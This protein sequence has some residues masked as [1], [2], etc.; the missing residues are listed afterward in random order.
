MR[1]LLGAVATVGLLTGCGG[2]Y[3]AAEVNGAAARLEYARVVGAESLAPYEY[4]YAKEHLE[5][6]QIEASQA[7]YSDAANY[8]E[9]AEEYA[10]KAVELAQAA[11]RASGR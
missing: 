7:S 5:Q 4:Y 10:N 2:V 1:I 8:A 3:Y 9:T 11:H 6:A